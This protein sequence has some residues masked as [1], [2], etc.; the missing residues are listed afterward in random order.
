MRMQRRT[1]EFTRVTVV[2][3][4]GGCRMP[5]VVDRGGLFFLL[6]RSLLC[7][8]LSG[9]LVRFGVTLAS[10][11]VEVDRINDFVQVYI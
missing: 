5:S 3:S 7:L 1:V 6:G 10:N 9:Q 8:F 4:G 2:R 11:F